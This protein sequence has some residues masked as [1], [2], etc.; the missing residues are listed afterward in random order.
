MR[1]KGLFVFIFVCMAGAVLA[2]PY[3]RTFIKKVESAH[4]YALWSQMGIVRADIVVE[5]AGAPYLKGKLYFEANGARS[6]LDLATGERVVFDGEKCWMSPADASYGSG[7][8]DVWT[9]PWFVVAP[10]KLRGEGTHLSEIQQGTW[11]EKKYWT[12]TQT[13]D[14]DQG[15]SPDDWYYLYVDP[16]TYLLKGMGYIVTY[17]KDVEEANK[18]PHGIIYEAYESVQGV[19][20]STQWKFGHFSKAEGIDDTLGSATLSNIQFINSST[21]IFTKPAG[22][23]ELIAP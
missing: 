22:S 10:F 8:F 23:R 5:F 2:I 12:T 20:F 16:K 18:E 13:F 7:R 19:M 4:G 17:G 14:A 21:H 6:R 11:N 3:K 15:D 9:W 1:Y